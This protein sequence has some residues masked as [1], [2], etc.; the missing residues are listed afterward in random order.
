MHAWDW[1]IVA[2]L[3]ANKD[4]LGPFLWLEVISPMA[5]GYEAACINEFDG[6]EFNVTQSMVTMAFNETTGSLAPTVVSTEV[7]LHGDEILERL[8]MQDGD[9][10]YD[11][12][13]LI[14]LVFV[15]RIIAFSFL[16]YRASRPQ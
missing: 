5:Y 13:L 16:F 10:L 12:L 6:A 14:V 2:G 15:T 9:I 4:R 11:C 8:G 7:L 3:L 1:I